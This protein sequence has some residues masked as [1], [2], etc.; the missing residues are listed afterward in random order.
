MASKKK[1]ITASQKLEIVASIESGEKQ[2]SVCQ[3]LGLAKT[4]VNT[5]WRG[6]DRL[7]QSIESADFGFD[8]KCFRPSHHKDVWYSSSGIV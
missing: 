5:I 6:K 2:S 8:S 3:R 7:K 1:A 4:I